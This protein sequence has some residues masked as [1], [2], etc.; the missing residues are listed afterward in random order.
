VY[1]IAILLELNRAPFDLS[2]GE[3]E[4]VS[5]YNVEYMRAGFV[6]FFLKEY[7]SLIFFRVLTSSLYFDGSLFAIYCV[8]TLLLYI[9]SCF[10]R[11]RYDMVIGLFWFILLPVCINLLYVSIV[12]S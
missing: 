4:L 12:L 3:S 9:R 11:I 5:G 7:G 6:L 10:P 2:E 8:V 1:L